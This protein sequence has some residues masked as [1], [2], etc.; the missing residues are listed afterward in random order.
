[1]KSLKVALVE[2]KTSFQ[3]YN[4]SKTGFYGYVYYLFKNLSKYNSNIEKVGIEI[5]STF[6]KGFSIMFDS[7]VRD[8]SKYNIVHN[9]DLNPFFPLRK[10]NSIII[11]TVHDLAFIFDK[12]SNEDVSHTLKDL[13]WSKLVTR[14][15]LY[16][17]LKSN[18]LIAVSTLTKNDLI[19]LGYDKDKIFVVNHGLDESFSSPV[20][21]KKKTDKFIIGYLGAMRTRKNPEFFINAFNKLHDDGYEMNVWG[22]LGYNREKIIKMSK[23]NK[24]IKFMGFAPENKKI[25]IYDS[26]NCFVFPSHY[27]GFG[28]PI[29]EAQARGLPV[30]IY[31]YGK[32]PK[33]VRKYCFE[34]ENPEHMAQII[35]SIRINGYNE[36]QQKKA[37]EYARSFTWERCAKG[38]LDVYRMVLK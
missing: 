2:A 13:V 26:F 7:I 16:S 10:G 15:G 14:L 33:E 22:K 27:E 6:G 25:S 11:S 36:K 30:I 37:T 4:T 8:F 1:M 21:I 23:G 5:N 18:Y 38:T 19:K 17:T 12:K 24:K 31:K 3:N 32:I 9:L 35:N 20:K 34:A 28:I 29:L